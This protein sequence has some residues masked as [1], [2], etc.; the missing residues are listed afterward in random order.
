MFGSYDK[1][2]IIR[3]TGPNIY[4]RGVGSPF[5]F[6]EMIV[7]EANGSCSGLPCPSAIYPLARVT[8]RFLEV[9]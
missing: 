2:P 4:G 1:Y 3:N 8:G 9:R 7:K 6:G 5:I